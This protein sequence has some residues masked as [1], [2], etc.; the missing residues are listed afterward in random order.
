MTRVLRNNRRA[1]LL[2]AGV[3]V[4]TFVLLGTGWWLLAGREG[5][6]SP[7]ATLLDTPDTRIHEWAG[8]ALAAVGALPLV[9][10]L[11]AAGSFIARSLRFERMDLRWFARWPAAVFT[12]RFGPHGGHFDPGQRIAN[13]VMV[14]ALLVLT[15]SGVGLVLVSGGTAFVWFLR[16]HKWS[17]YVLTPVVAGH[18]LIGLGILPGYKG[19]WRAIHLSGRVTDQTAR[20]LWPAWAEEQLTDPSREPRDATRPPRTG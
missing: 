4:T 2:H 11:R 5:D 1:R 16:L 12:G 8:Y 15:V 17:T 20:R 9:F 19:T 3:Y 10:G 18:V 7:V 13:L 14:G 6:P